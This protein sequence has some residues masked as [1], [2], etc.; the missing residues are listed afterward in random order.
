M[1]GKE[2]DDSPTW[3][4]DGKD[5][6]ADFFPDEWEISKFY[7]RDKTFSKS[8]ITACINDGTHFINI[9]AHG[10]HSSCAGF[11][12]S[13]IENLSNSTYPIVYS[14]GCYNASLD[15]SS[16]DAIGEVWVISS[17]AGVAFIGN[18]RYGWYMPGAS[19]VNGPSEVFDKEFFS[20]L[21]YVFGNFIHKIVCF[22]W[23]INR[24]PSNINFR[25]KINI[26]TANS[27]IWLSI[28]PIVI[29]IKSS[30]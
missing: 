3:G 24:C 29:V 26:S 27:I 9:L 28:D 2:L 16:G 11:T 23:C 15:G 1:I 14:Q 25:E 7:D 18:T 10:S 30:I 17:N 22:F 20:V 8:D 21:F 19:V 13:E 4:G 12:N 6:V 5:A